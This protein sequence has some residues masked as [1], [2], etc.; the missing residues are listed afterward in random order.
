M[1]R[2]DREAPDIGQGR[3]GL[4][5]TVQGKTGPGKIGKDTT[6]LDMT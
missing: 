3:T 5:W 4:D 2:Q 6:R 1:T